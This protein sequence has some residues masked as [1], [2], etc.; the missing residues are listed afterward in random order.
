VLSNNYQARHAVAGVAARHNQ[1]FMFAACGRQ[2]RKE[3]CSL[4]A[5]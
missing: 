1:R 5:S 3:R 2:T 4:L